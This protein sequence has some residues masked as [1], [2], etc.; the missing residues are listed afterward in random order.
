MVVLLSS[1]FSPRPLASS[2]SSSCS[3]LGHPSCCR[4]LSFSLPST[5]CYCL[6]A[7]MVYVSS[8]RD[9]SLLLF[10]FLVLWIF[11]HSSFS[12]TLLLAL[13]LLR[14]SLLLS[15]DLC[16]FYP[17]S[18]S[19]LSSTQYLRTLRTRHLIG[20]RAAFSRWTKAALRSSSRRCV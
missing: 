10:S 12:C 15:S 5:S 1:L 9:C 4:L 19:P 3:L 11:F 14:F 2:S 13:L 18:L 16:A 20:A 6:C 17:F 8:Y 7:C